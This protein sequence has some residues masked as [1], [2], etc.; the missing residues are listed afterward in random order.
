MCRRSGS[1]CGPRPVGREARA[2]RAL[3]PA[4]LRADV[5]LAEPGWRDEL[6][7]ALRAVRARPGA[8][9]ELALF[10]RERRRARAACEA[11]AGADVARVLV[12]PEGAR[13]VTPE[14]TTPPELVASRASGL[15][16]EG[17][18]FAGGTDMYFCELNRTRP[19]V[20]AIDGV[21]WSLNPQVHAFDDISLLETPEAQG[22]QVRTAQ[23]FAGGQAALRRP[24]D[25]QAPL[26]RQRHVA[27]A[28]PDPPD[29]RQALPI[30]AAW[31]AA[32]V[33]HSR[34]GRRRHHVLRDDGPARRRRPGDAPGRSRCSAMLPPAVAPTARAAASA[35]SGT[36]SGLAA[37]R[38]PRGLVAMRRDERRTP[39]S[40][41]NVR[42]ST[43]DRAARPRHC[44]NDRARAVRGSSRIERLDR[45]ERDLSEKQTAEPSPRGSS[46]GR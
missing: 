2:A 25:A 6:T 8:A 37:A 45:K 19:Q 38:R 40:R 28:E 34:S 12:A 20:E 26:Q 24:G 21:F 4:H 9:L 23:A 1:R 36:T 15:A 39:P 22:E 43:G 46:A 29:P 42:R 30:G 31:T 44:T 13:T 18:P 16:L 17:V 10:L 14:E 41:G 7:R 27:D 32:S 33:K 5:H 35:R 11:L 3:A